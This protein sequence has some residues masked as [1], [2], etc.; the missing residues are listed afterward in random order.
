MNKEKIG[1]WAL[2]IG[3][4]GLVLLFLL[5]RLGVQKETGTS[6][7]IQPVES[8]AAKAS[9]ADRSSPRPRPSPQIDMLIYYEPG[10][11]ETSGLVVV[12]F[13][14]QRVRNAALERELSNRYAFYKTKS[15]PIEPVE[16]QMPREEWLKRILF[17]VEGDAAAGRR[18]NVSY[19]IRKW[20]GKESV[21]FTAFEE[22]DLMIE[23]PSAAKPPAG[24]KLSANLDVGVAS[25]V[26]NTIT[27][28][29]PAAGPRADAVLACRVHQLLEAAGPLQDA[30][31][32]LL[33]TD[34]ADFDGYWFLGQAL[35]M[36]GKLDAALAAYEDA[37]KRSPRLVKNDDEAPFHVMFRLQELSRT[38]AEKKP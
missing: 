24:A 37:L 27:V 1:R 5:G 31:E 13:S 34:P 22:C 32:K 19:A 28:P 33:A 10:G 11:T 12:S 21:K 4:T 36:R 38:L 25:I 18:I 26:S 15:S 29:S 2:G 3:L 23:I 7:V 16:L 30:A 20:P 8:L 14:C 6:E 9:G 35:E 17:S